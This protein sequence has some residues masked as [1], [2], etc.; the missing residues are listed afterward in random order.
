MGAGIGVQPIG[1]T[2]LN[3]LGILENI[4]SHGSRIDRLH[5]LT[6]EGKTVLDLKYGDFRPELYGVGLHRDAL[7]RALYDKTKET[8]STIN[9]VAG[10]K[11]TSI[12]RGSS[13]SYFDVE[14]SLE[15][16]GPYD[17]VVVADGRDSVPMVWCSR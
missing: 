13:G 14:G 8:S 4:L 12:T 3:R 11:I 15:K 1:L 6:R 16:E 10:T 9:V 2:V 7:F 5:S 17:L